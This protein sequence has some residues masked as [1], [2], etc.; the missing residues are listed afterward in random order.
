M[1]RTR[2]LLALTTF[3]AIA[4]PPLGAA[5]ARSRYEVTA[6]DE[7]DVRVAGIFEGTRAHLTSTALRR[8][9]AI[10]W[11][12]SLD[13]D[14]REASLDPAGARL[15]VVALFSGVRVI[16]PAGWDVDVRRVAVFGGVDARTERP[17]GSAPRLTIDAVAAFAGIQVTDRPVEDEPDVLLEAPAVSAVPAEPRAAGPDAEAAVAPA[18]A[19][20]RI[21]AGAEEP[22]GS[23]EVAAADAD[24][25]GDSSAEPA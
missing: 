7:D 3:A 2:K 21:E 14:L 15:R 22:S 12:G 13:V 10:A 24:G 6:T 17:L 18:E 20:A 11:Y 5:I 23:A 9:E 8:G 16:V 25:D 4:L 19:E 1:G